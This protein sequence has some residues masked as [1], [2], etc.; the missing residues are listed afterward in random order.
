MGRLFRNFYI[1]LILSPLLFLSSC[2][3]IGNGEGYP[4][5]KD[6]H[7]AQNALWTCTDE[8]EDYY[9]AVKNDKSMTLRQSNSGLSYDYGNLNEESCGDNCLVYTSENAQLEILEANLNES[10]AFFNS[11]EPMLSDLELVCKKN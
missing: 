3:L 1:F 10:P 11:N 2:W 7:S 6:E 8:S 5:F 9:L 4:G